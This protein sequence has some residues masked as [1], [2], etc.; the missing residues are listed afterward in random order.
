M[1]GKRYSDLYRQ[2]TGQSRS[3]AEEKETADLLSEYGEDWEQSDELSELMLFSDCLPSN[4]M[5]GGKSD[6]R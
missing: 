5:F 3:Q 2:I 6:R 1:K 4:V